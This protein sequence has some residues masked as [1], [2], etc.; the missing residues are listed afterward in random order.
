[1]ILFA[2][3]NNRYGN[4]TVLPALKTDLQNEAG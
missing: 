2:G 3:A 1:M 4:I